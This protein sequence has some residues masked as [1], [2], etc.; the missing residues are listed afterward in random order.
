MSSETNSIKEKK[1]SSEEKSDD[2]ESFAYG[3]TGAITYIII[4]VWILGTCLLYTTK[5]SRSGIINSLNINPFNANPVNANYV[6]EF[7]ISTKSPYI[8]LGNY[9]AQKLSFLKD[10]LTIIENFIKYLK[11]F[12]TD[13]MTY[14]S[15]L[16]ENFYKI[17]NSVLS[18]IYNLLY[19]FNESLLMLFSPFIYFFIFIFYSIFYFW[20][21]TFFQIYNSIKILF[22]PTNGKKYFWSSVH[23]FLN[24]VLFPFYI[25]LMICLL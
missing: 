12:N 23:P 9:T 20:G 25:F 7:S 16:F 11:S 13:S 3:F 24:F 1:K 19:E 22:F 8:N 6:K 18:N 4:F 10:D 2:W 15:E 17:N 14:L 21:L 5:V